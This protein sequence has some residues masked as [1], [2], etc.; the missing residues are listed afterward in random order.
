MANLESFK[1]VRTVA[2]FSAIIAVGVTSTYFYSEINKIKDQQEEMAKSLAAIIPL[3]NPANA[4]QLTKALQTINSIDTRLSKAQDDIRLLA[5][6]VAE[7]PEPAP[8]KVYNRL[9]QRQETSHQLPET[10]IAAD[11]DDDI[12]AMA[13]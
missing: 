12:R 10:S 3:V 1:D 6:G 8:V 9:T 2:S 4:K 5:E 11:I 7:I 13:A